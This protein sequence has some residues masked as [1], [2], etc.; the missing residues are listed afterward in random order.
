MA[1]RC[2]IPVIQNSQRNKK[3]EEEYQKKE[4]MKDLWSKEERV[5]ELEKELTAVISLLD[6]VQNKLDLAM[7][8][9]SHID[10]PIARETEREIFE[11]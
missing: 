7:E 4:A 3:M 1:K 2:V 10:N 11:A 9:L 8:G 5:R 6:R